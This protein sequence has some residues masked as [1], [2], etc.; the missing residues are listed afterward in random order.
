MTNK[1]ELPIKQSVTIHEI[2]SGTESR[3]WQIVAADG[4]ARFCTT[5]LTLRDELS[6]L[7]L[8]PEIAG[9]GAPAPVAAVKRRGRPRKASLAT[10]AAGEV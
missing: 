6:A 8:L 10:V 7:L 4:S 2:A 9:A 3:L 1:I 5:T